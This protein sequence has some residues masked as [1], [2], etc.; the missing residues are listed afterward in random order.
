MPDLQ[1]T[2]WG[3]WR[4]KHPRREF[5]PEPEGPDYVDRD[6]AA[7]IK[8]TIEAYWAAR[9]HVVQVVLVNA[10]FHPAIR[11]ARYDV[12]SDLVNGLPKPQAQSARNRAA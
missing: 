11:C 2:S 12:R 3:D 7:K 8:A 5:N 1:N 6:G 4:A 10:G 9:G